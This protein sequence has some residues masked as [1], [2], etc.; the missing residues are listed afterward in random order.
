MDY[1]K[2]I[3]GLIIVDFD[4]TNQVLTGESAIFRYL[5]KMEIKYASVSDVYTLIEPTIQLES[6]LLKCSQ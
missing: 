5:R 3:L 1:I 4:L 2:E 6:K